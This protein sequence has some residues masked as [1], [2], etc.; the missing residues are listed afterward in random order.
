[1][2]YFER[3]YIRSYLNYCSS[4]LRSKYGATTTFQ[5]GVNGHVAELEAV[6][7]HTCEKGDNYVWYRR[8]MCCPGERVCIYIH[9]YIHTYIFVY[10]V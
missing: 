4:Y 2:D 9:T 8:G 6:T 5:E 3:I 10:Y 1:M 7:L